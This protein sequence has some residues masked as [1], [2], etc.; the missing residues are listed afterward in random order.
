MTTITALLPNYERY[1]RYELQRADQ[2]VQAY[3]SDLRGLSRALDKEVEAIARNDLR[4]YMLARGE[5][6]ISR[7]T[8]RRSIQGMS[9]FWKWLV[10]EGVVPANVTAGITVPRRE[11]KFARF[12]TEAELRRFVDT[13]DTERNALAWALLAWLGLRRN[14]LLHLR[15]GDVSLSDKLLVVRDTKDK[16]DRTLPLPD[17]LLPALKQACAGRA[18]GCCVVAGDEGGYWTHKCFYGAFRRHCAAAGLVGITPHTLRHTLA[19]HLSQR[20]VPVR[21][22]QQL[23]GHRRLETTAR[24]LQ[25]APEFMGVVLELHVLNERA[26]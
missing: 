7:S 18:A 13:P 12:L 22:I 5:A 8:V 9:T 20:G 16:E 26:G 3:L 21:V 10:N 19:T 25:V 2:T 24:Y 1:L 11:R 15:V 23:L 14:E 4:A 6:G 17:A